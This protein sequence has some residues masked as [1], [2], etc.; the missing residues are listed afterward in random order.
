MQK[1]DSAHRSDFAFEHL[2]DFETI[3]ANILRHES[4][5]QGEFFMKTPKI[6][7]IPRVSL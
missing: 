2:S 3:F 6:E 5:A 4:A 1:H 7:N